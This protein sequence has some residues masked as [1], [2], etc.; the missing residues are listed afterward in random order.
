MSDCICVTK[1]ILRLQ[2]VPW[3]KIITFFLFLFCALILFLN[4]ILLK[5]NFLSIYYAQAFLVLFISFVIGVLI[6]QEWAV[7]EIS[8]DILRYRRFIGKISFSLPASS[9]RY[10]QVERSRWLKSRGSLD[11]AILV[12]EHDVKKYSLSLG[13]SYVIGR[14]VLTRCRLLAHAL[15][16]PIHDDWGRELM[17]SRFFLKR[18]RGYGDDWKLLLVILLL[19]TFLAFGLYKLENFFGQ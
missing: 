13:T 1:E 2:I 8:P 14:P 15:R 11:Q 18:W 10:I 17:Q 3:A 4:A 9:A 5:Q 7:F 12:L 19:A 6:V 16:I